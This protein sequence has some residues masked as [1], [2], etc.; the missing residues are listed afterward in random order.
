[1]EISRCRVIASMSFDIQ[2]KETESSPPVTLGYNEFKAMIQRGEL[3]PKS[4]VCDPVLTGNDWWPLDDLNVFHTHSPASHP[5]GARLQRKQEDAKYW[6]QRAKQS[7]ARHAAYVK[8]D[9]L[10]RSFQLIPLPE[11]IDGTNTHGATRLYVRPS[12][13][14]ERIFTFLFQRDVIQIDACQGRTSLWYSLPQVGSI[15]GVIRETSGRSFDPAQIDRAS[16]KLRYKRAPEPFKRWATVVSASQL[17]PSCSTPLCDGVG[18]RHEV[19]LP[20]GLFVADW[21]NP[22]GVE[23]APQIKLLNSYRKCVVVAKLERFWE[24]RSPEAPESKG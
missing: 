10:A 3:A 18:F 2:F 7:W 5:P 19:M 4:L 22:R 1:M 12:F 6:E 24:G 23:H 16:A 21:S 20:T 13:E 9:L 14:P 8:G 15:D 11:L 17:A